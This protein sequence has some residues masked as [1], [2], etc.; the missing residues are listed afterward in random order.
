MVS[1][2]T[3]F[4]RWR[5]LGYSWQRKE[6]EGS[7]VATVLDGELLFL[8]FL[9]GGYGDVKSIEGRLQIEQVIFVVV[10]AAGGLVIAAGG[11][12]IAATS[13]R[14]FRF[15]F[16]ID[17]SDNHV[18]GAAHLDI[19]VVAA[20]AWARVRKKMNLEGRLGTSLDLHRDCCCT[21]VLRCCVFTEWD[22]VG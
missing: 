16:L 19:V 9:V 17:L 1:G 14:A 20:I 18:S 21:M 10:W 4:E 2:E 5:L 22:F 12:V 13:C 8:D 15:C 11:L 3:R 7:V 6:G